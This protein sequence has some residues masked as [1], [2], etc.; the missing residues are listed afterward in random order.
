MNHASVLSSTVPVLPPIGQLRLAAAAPVPRSTTPRS[1]F[2]MTNAVSA[3]MTSVACVRFSSSRLPSRS[4]TLSTSIGF[5]RTP[6][7]GNTV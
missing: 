3:R 1:R 6:P 5:M 7:F 2:V 4:I